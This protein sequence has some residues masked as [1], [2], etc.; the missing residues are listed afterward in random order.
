MVFGGG[1]VSE[2]L[3]AKLEVTSISGD[4]VK[5]EDASSQ[6]EDRIVSVNNVDVGEYIKRIGDAI[7][8]IRDFSANAKAMDYRVESVNFTFER[9]G[10]EYVISVH[11]KMS[12]KPKGAGAK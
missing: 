11:T 8:K 2:K 4:S 10:V 3:T 7:D 12:V 9:V 6:K 5:V 1:I